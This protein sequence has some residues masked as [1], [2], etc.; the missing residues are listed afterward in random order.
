MHCFFFFKHIFFSFQ[1]RNL[2]EES[3]DE[4][5]VKS[6]TV[7]FTDL[8]TVIEAKSVVVLKCIR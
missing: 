8:I 5:E 6:R 3:T 2:S 4:S 1:G 7:Q